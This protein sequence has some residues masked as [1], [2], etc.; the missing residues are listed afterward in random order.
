MLAKHRVSQS[1][2]IPNR[3]TGG[4][5]FVIRWPSGSASA[6]FVTGFS[7]LIRLFEDRLRLVPIA[8]R[9]SVTAHFDATVRKAG[10]GERRVTLAKWGAADPLPEFYK[11][12]RLVY[13]RFPKERDYPDTFVSFEIRND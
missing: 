8:E 2:R 6:S 5:S 13:R 3:A 1:R 12:A 10:G 4:L 11:R 7:N 9:D